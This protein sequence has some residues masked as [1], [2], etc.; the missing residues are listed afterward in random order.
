MDVLN[1]QAL[2]IEDLLGKSSNAIVESMMAAKK[3]FDSMDQS[4]LLQN[5][6]KRI[7][8]IPLTTH[9]NKNCFQKSY[10]GDPEKPQ[11]D[12]LMGK[13]LFYI[14][15]QGYLFLDMTAGH[16]QMTWG[17]NHSILIQA[18]QEGLANGI[19]WDCHSSIPGDFVKKLS[20]ELIKICYEDDPDVQ[21]GDFSVI[22]KDENALNTVFLGTATGS[23][24]CSTAMKLA[25]THFWATKGKERIPV[26]VSINGNYHGTDIMMQRVRGMWDKFFTNCIFEMI[27]PNDIDALKAVFKRCGEDIAA[28]FTEPILM[29]REAML[30]SK[31]FLQVARA[32]TESVNALMV[33]DEIQTGFWCPDI[34]M[35]KRFDIIPDVI[36]IGKGMTAGFHPLSGLIY[37]RKFDRLAQYDSIST[38]GSA[39]LPAYVTLCSLELIKKERERIR[40]IGEY[41]HQELEKLREEFPELVVNISGSGFLSGIKFKDQPIALKFHQKCIDAGMWLR[42][43]AYHEGHSTALTKFALILNKDVVDFSLRKFRDILKVLD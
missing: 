43:H 30:L 37:K 13:G 1:S 17:Y 6:G 2:D 7:S 11:N 40:Q 19:A 9:F 3:Y 35:Y 29:N 28:F 26:F 22:L 24:S 41:Y 8:S 10:A 20:Y 32:L 12:L 18:I 15:E 38:N 31:E 34:F 27:E 36:V 42:V 33:I 4:S 21:A 39:P 5:V 16:Y 14:T 23:V 25:I